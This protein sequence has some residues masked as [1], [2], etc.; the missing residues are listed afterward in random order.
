MG[1]IFARA[2]LALIVFSCVACGSKR[3]EPLDPLH[4]TITGSVVE[5]VRIVQSGKFAED[6]DKNFAEKQMT[7][8]HDL[9]S[10]ARDIRRIAAQPAITPPDGR[11]TAVTLR[12]V[13]IA[14]T[15]LT[16]QVEPFQ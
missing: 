6:C 9:D 14:G 16:E 5:A 11:A 10:R 15:Y 3:T 7:I 4:E 8:A 12:N 1:E 2:A 13:P